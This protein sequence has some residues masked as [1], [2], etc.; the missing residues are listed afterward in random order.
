MNLIKKSGIART[1][2][3]LALFSVF[4]SHPNRGNYAWRAARIAWNGA[5]TVGSVIFL[6]GGILALKA[7][8]AQRPPAEISHEI[9]MGTSIMLLGLGVNGIYH[10]VKN[11]RAECSECMEELDG[12]YAGEEKG[13]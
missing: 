2:L 8:P 1:L 12:E 3:V 6:M 7:E 5:Q 10:G 13:D 9:M 11:M 4:S